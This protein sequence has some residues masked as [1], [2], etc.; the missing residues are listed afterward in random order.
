LLT[1]PPLWAAIL[2][3][4]LY[5]MLE[6]LA[7][8]IPH[9]TAARVIGWMRGA[10]VQGAFYVFTLSILAAQEAFTAL[11]IGLAGFILFR[12]G[13]V[14]RVFTPVLRPVLRVLYPLPVPDQVLR[15][16]IVRTALKHRLELSQL[17]DMASDMMNMW[18][19]RPDEP[20]SARRDR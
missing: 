16:L 4:A 6:M 15:G 14:D 2:G 8:S 12:W 5:V 11:G 13:V 9:P 19:D 10:A 1:L 7:P 18:S 17:D 20:P 3:G